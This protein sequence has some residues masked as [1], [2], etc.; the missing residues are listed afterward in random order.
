MFQ[1][2]VLRYWHGRHDEGAEGALHVRGSLRGGQVPV[3]DT[4]R[5]QVGFNTGR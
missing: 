1:F 3:R 4:G 5:Y 2:H